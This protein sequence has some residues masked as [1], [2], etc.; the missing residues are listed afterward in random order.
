M[1]E[2]EWVRLVGWPTKICIT[3][4]RFRSQ[5]HAV[6]RA[7]FLRCWV[8]FI[9]DHQC[10]F[11]ALVGCV[12]CVDS[13]Q[14]RYSEEIPTLHAKSYPLFSAHHLL[15]LPKSVIWTEYLSLPLPDCRH[16]SRK[17]QLPLITKFITLE[18][19]IHFPLK[20]TGVGRW[21]KMELYKSQLLFAVNLL[22]TEV[23]VVIYFPY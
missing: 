11:S 13:L 21:L 16:P 5:T 19:T 8:A 14:E 12:E 7:T 10:C 15:T 23:T 9:P 22:V 6:C 17:F 20:I 3:L 4:P 2:N 1:N 18:R